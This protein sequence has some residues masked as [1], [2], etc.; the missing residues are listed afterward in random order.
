[1]NA[2]GF[3]WL[4]ANGRR[5]GVSEFAKSPA[6]LKRI[7]KAARNKRTGRTNA[8]YGANMAVTRAALRKAYIT[9]EKKKVG[10]LSAGWINAAR[11][12]KTPGRYLP[13]WI[14]RHGAGPGGTQTMKSGGRVM[15]RISNSND[16]FGAGWDRRLAYVISRGEKAMLSA[17]KNILESE[18]R[19]AERRMGR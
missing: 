6:D 7:H 5:Y 11:D 1:M 10:L 13:T 3:K 12:L 9:Q 14:T 4:A 15:I 16:W 19:K 8:G 17:T 2:G 18:A